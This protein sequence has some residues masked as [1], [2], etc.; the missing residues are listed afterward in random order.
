MKKNLLTF[1]ILLLSVCFF[2]AKTFSQEAPGEWADGAEI[3]GPD[4]ST[5]AKLTNY[6]N[7]VINRT[8][9]QYQLP[10]VSKVSLTLYNP[11]GQLINTLFAGHNKAGSYEIELNTTGIAGGIY[12][13]ILSV[14]S[15]NKTSHLIRKIKIVK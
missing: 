14:T 2:S 8:S 4:P 10:A 3:V 15:A 9:I 6:P 1:S 11:N 12:I 7:P 5:Q 13:C